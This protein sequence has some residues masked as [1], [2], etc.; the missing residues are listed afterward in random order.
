M[1]ARR[2]GVVAWFVLLAGAAFAQDD[3]DELAPGLIAEYTAG[4][5]TVR[6]IDGDLAFDWATGSPDSRLPAGPF[7]ARWSGQILL[8]AEGRYRWHAYLQGDLSVRIN[9][10]IVFQGQSERPQ[11]ISG[12]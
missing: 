11:W 7:S 2:I 1:S 9:D 12:D 5:Q 10:Q 6:R 8:R 3:D 4:E